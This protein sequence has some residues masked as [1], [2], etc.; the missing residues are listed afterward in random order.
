[1]LQE[2]FDHKSPI[3]GDGPA[4]IAHWRGTKVDDEW[5]FTKEL[6][7]LHWVPGGLSKTDMP[8]MMKNLS[9]ALKQI[10]FEIQARD[11]RVPM[12]REKNTGHDIAGGPFPKDIGKRIKME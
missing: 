10:G 2:P 8:A 9:N 11:E 4:L 7:I 12:T 6:D 3:A 5:H 1:M